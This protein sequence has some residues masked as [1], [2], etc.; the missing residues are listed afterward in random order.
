MSIQIKLQPSGVVFD[1]DSNES[2]LD[3][4]LRNNRP[5]RY[6]CNNGLCGTCV[7]TVVEGEFENEDPKGIL[8]EDDKN[9]GKIL[10]CC[11]KALSDAV[12]QA[13]YF[14][15][16]SG[17]KKILSP[18]KVNSIKFPSEDVAVIS[19]RLPGSVQFEYVEGQYVELSYQ[20]I[21]RS[22]S[23]ANAS[24]DR[25]NIELHIGKVEGGL[26]SS[27]VF[28]EFKDN[29]LVR[30]EGPCG[31]FYLRPGERGVIFLAG[32][33]GFAPIK[34][35]IESMIQKNDL[36]PV[37][38]YWGSRKKSGLYSN[39]PNSWSNRYEKITYVPVISDEPPAD[40]SGKTGLVHR[41]VLHDFCSL[42]EFDVYACGAEAMINAAKTDFLD[43]GLPMN[44]FY[45]D[46]FVSS[47]DE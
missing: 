28:S 37:Y 7:S 6:S 41:A 11:A 14:P 42:S 34:S 35:I 26:L 36:R 5:L 20:G 9:S 47:A 4:A 45:S 10:T 17:I 23:I 13:E 43:A 38:L 19:L 12:I 3:A 31:S 29:H 1:A 40:W 33:T 44:R 21:K 32:G 22:Y 18:A 39:A 25:N 2:L 16:L 15:E 46:V 27:K 30:I 8:S 24:S